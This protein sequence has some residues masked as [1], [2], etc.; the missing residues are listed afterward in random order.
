[1]AAEARTSHYPHLLQ[2]L[3]KFRSRSAGKKPVEY[4]ICASAFLKKVFKA[5]PHLNRLRRFFEILDSR[6]GTV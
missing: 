2:P 5:K 1:M 6:V 3:N 4:Q